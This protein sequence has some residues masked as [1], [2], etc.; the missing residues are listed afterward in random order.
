MVLR[1]GVSQ[2]EGV[3]IGEPLPP[4]YDAVLAEIQPQVPVEFKDKAQQAA[5]Y[6]HALDSNKPLYDSDGNSLSAKVDLLTD[7]LI[8]SAFIFLTYVHAK[9]S[10]F[11]PEDALPKWV[12]E[13][14]NARP[15]GEP[16]TLDEEAIERWY[17]D[18]VDQQKASLKISEDGQEHYRYETGSIPDTETAK[19]AITNN[20]KVYVEGRGLTDL[21][22]LQ[23]AMENLKE[24]QIHPNS[25]KL[26]EGDRLVLYWHTY[27]TE[28]LGKDIRNAF[29]Q[30][31]VS[32]RGL[33]QDPQRILV[34]KDGSYKIESKTSNDGSLGEGGHNPF[35]WEGKQYDPQTFFRQYIA[36]TFYGCKDPTE[37]YKIGYVPVIN[38]GDS[39][40][41]KVDETIS[42]LSQTIGSIDHLPVYVT[43]NRFLNPFRVSKI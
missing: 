19:G 20:F 31:G 3:R 11:N 21:A 24:K 27:P 22:R 30:K 9:F 34:N 28:K 13:R 39:S 38:E 26:F 10:K 36:L 15:K 25:S 32:I 4:M 7:Q 12:I 35:I 6:F 29:S 18:Y 1:E 8:G 23:K 14:R 33:A 2:T 16:Y 41:P 5:Y 40:N 43:T 17:L 42:K 37:P